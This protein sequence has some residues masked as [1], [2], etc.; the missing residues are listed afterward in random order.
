MLHEGVLVS[1]VAALGL[2]CRRHFS[3]SWPTSSISC[4]MRSRTCL[5]SRGRLST[6]SS[7]SCRASIPEKWKRPAELGTMAVVTRLSPQDTSPLKVA[8]GSLRRST[9]ASQG[10]VHSRQTA[11]RACSCQTRSRLL[12]EGSRKDGVTT[13][14]QTWCFIEQSEGPTGNTGPMTLRDRLI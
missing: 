14:R 9:R 10:P 11:L 4:Y 7:S 12:E 5:T 13:G 3:E 1:T 2:R 8:I 6:S